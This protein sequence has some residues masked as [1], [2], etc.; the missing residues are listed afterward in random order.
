MTDTLADNW[1]I[2]ATLAALYALGIYIYLA[3]Y[4]HDRRKN[5]HDTSAPVAIVIAIGWPVALAVAGVLAVGI[6]VFG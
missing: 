4:A 3:S 6:L 1:P 5:Q 2:V